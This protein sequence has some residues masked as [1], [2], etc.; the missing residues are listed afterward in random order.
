MSKAARGESNYTD[1]NGGRS[2]SSQDLKG[3]AR[4]SS[5]LKEIREDPF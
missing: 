3:I 2:I 5:I 4:S 1:Y